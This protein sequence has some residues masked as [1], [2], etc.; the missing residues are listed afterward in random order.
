MFRLKAVWSYVVG[1]E[2]RLTYL[3]TVPLKYLSVSYEIKLTVRCL[4]DATELI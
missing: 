3:F 2:N 4:A 1:V